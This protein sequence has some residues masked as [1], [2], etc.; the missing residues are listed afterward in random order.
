MGRRYVDC[1]L[2]GAEEVFGP[3][4]VHTLKIVVLLLFCQSGR[5]MNKSWSPWEAQRLPSRC[6]SSGGALS[7]CRRCS[8]PPAL[9]WHSRGTWRLGGAYWMVSLLG[10]YVEGQPLLEAV[11]L[12]KPQLGETGKEG[13]P[14]GRLSLHSQQVSCDGGR[15]RWGCAAPRVKL[16][17]A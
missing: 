13:R 2:Q 10:E 4:S 17:F 1:P 6:E 14:R 15:G 9:T 12:T 3:S 16:F 5:G 7:V 8:L 11:P